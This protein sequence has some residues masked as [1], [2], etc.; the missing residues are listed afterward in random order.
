MGPLRAERG[1][2]VNCAP[3]RRELRCHACSRWHPGS[4]R[5]PP[6]TRILMTCTTSR[7][8]SIR[9][10]L[11]PRHRRGRHAVAQRGPRS[12]DADHIAVSIKSLGHLVS[13]ACAD[14]LP[15]CA[16]PGVARHPNTTF[17]RHCGVRLRAWPHLN[18]EEAHKVSTETL[19]TEIGLKRT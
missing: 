9:T 5:D 12:C 7:D 19:S 6:S 3:G 4:S 1:C 14:A 17:L 11:Q 8:V 13:R 16:H 15:E 2:P 18:C 10:C